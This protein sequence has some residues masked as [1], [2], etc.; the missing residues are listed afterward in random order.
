MHSANMSKVARNIV[1]LTSQFHMRTLK[2]WYAQHQK[3][4]IWAAA[5]SSRIWDEQATHLIPASPK[6]IMIIT[7]PTSKSTALFMQNPRWN[8]IAVL[9]SYHLSLVNL[10]HD[11]DDYWCSKDLMLTLTK[12]ELLLLQQPGM[13]SPPKKSHHAIHEIWDLLDGSS[14]KSSSSSHQT[15]PWNPMFPLSTPENVVKRRQ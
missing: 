5:S 7:A 13:Q 4:K 15:S 8:K 9:M 14:S 1:S 12:L 11:D 6:D 10:W 2:I 3:K